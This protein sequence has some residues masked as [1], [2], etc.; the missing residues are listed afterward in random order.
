MIESRKP[1]SLAR[2]LGFPALLCITLGIALFLRFFMISAIGISGDDTI[3]YLSLTRG[4][5][6]E[7]QPNF[8]IVIRALYSLAYRMA[9]PSD[10]T[11][12]GLNASLDIANTLLVFWISLRL[13]GRAGPKLS[14]S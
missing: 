5:A 12:K 1:G 8:R 9:G 10:W 11:I 4:W 7:Q 14:R 6:E 2:E 3:Y 13:A